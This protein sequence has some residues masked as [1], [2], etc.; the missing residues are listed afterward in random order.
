M[1]DRDPLQE[2][3]QLSARLKED[4]PPSVHVAPQVIRRVRR[5]EAASERTLAL[6]AAGSCVA[7]IAVA[8]AGFSQLSELAD[9]L[10]AFLQI[11]P[12]IGP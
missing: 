10:E 4:L 5:A 9:P 1:R 2:F 11:V 6:L 12:P 3:E 8:V 7:A